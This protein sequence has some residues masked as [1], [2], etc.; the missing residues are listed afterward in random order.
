MMVEDDPELTMMCR[1]GDYMMCYHAM[2]FE[3]G[4]FEPWSK[5]R[6][7]PPYDAH[8]PTV[9]NI[10]SYGAKLLQDAHTCADK[11]GARLHCNHSYL[12]LFHDMQM[13]SK[14]PP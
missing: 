2:K 10:P 5:I 1:L 4:P 13:T 8:M 11:Y 9:L 14:D 7:S 6:T 12:L 3:S